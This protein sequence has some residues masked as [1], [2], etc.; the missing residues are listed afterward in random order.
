MGQHAPPVGY[1]PGPRTYPDHWLPTT[2]TDGHARRGLNRLID[3]VDLAAPLGH[4]R[5]DWLDH[6]ALDRCIATW[7]DAQSNDDLRIALIAAVKRA[8]V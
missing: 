4:R 3:R 8:D 1:N 7:I 5:P 2:E 6:G